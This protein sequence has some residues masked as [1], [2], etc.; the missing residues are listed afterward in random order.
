ME[1]KKERKK[2]AAIVYEN[3]QAWLFF[4]P[5][6]PRPCGQERDIK[7]LRFGKVD[8]RPFR[9]RKVPLL[10]RV[11][12]YDE[13]CARQAA[14]YLAHFLGFYIGLFLSPSPSRILTALLLNQ[15]V[16]VSV[17]PYE[18]CGQASRDGKT[19]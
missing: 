12:I 17:Q 16:Q 1:A 9:A 15:V 3:Q 14:R 19:L 6:P 11:C 13:L 8:S 7:E 18:R 10:S 4:S 5:P 2:K